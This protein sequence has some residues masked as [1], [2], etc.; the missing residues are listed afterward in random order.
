MTDKDKLNAAFK[1]LRKQGFIAK[2]NFQCCNSCAGYEIAT[3]VK[4]MPEAKRAKVKG[5][6]TYNRQ[7]TERAFHPRW[8]NGHLLITYGPVTVDEVGEFGLPTVEVGNALKAALE[9]QGLK[10]KWDGNPDSCIGVEF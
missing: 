3:Q 7:S 6:V 5:V 4:E 2:Q 8:G 9:E 10:V 1:N